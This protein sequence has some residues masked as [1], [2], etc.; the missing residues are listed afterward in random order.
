MHRKVL[1]CERAD[2]GPMRLA[3][4]VRYLRY[5]FRRCWRSAHIGRTRTLSPTRTEYQRA[6]FPPYAPMLGMTT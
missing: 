3:D 6:I 5:L 1:I 2:V 4:L